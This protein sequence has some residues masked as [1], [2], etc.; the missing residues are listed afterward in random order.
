MGVMMRDLQRQRRDELGLYLAWD[1]LSGPGPLALVLVEGLT[2]AIAVEM[3][4]G[5]TGRPGPTVARV[6]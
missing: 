6:I 1:G 3:I 2:G 5:W 4:C